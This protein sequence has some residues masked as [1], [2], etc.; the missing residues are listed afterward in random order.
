MS[1]P[2]AGGELLHGVLV[3][4]KCC[5]GA[6]SSSL[7]TVQA[8]NTQ[9]GDVPDGRVEEAMVMDFHGSHSAEPPSSGSRPG[10]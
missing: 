9:F 5:A 2:G 6:S 7:S 8:P 4:H 3:V 10:Q 1:L